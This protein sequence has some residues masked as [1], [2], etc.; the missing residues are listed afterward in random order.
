MKHLQ[1]NDE[2]V[3][4]LSLTNTRSYF[5]SIRILVD[6]IES[7]ETILSRIYVALQLSVNNRKLKG[8][9]WA[10]GTKYVGSPHE[11]AIGLNSKEAFME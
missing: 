2:N 1:L 3:I 11:K 6:F 10:A 8:G 4:S 5:R 9:I 7:W